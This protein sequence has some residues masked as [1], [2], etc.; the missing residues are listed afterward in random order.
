M[1]IHSK[2]KQ[3]QK[4][5][6]RTVTENFYSDSAEHQDNMSYVILKYAS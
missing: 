3:E 4:S 1:N 5:A 6:T 2:A